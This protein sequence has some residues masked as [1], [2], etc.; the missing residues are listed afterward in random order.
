V[1]FAIDNRPEH[2]SFKVCQDTIGHASAYPI[3]NSS[4]HIKTGVSR[5]NKT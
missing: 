3:G 2:A 5:N 1:D 4:S